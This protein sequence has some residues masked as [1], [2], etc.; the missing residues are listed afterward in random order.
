MELTSKVSIYAR[1]VELSQSYRRTQYCSSVA[2]DADIFGVLQDVHLKETI[3]HLDG[4][5]DYQLVEGGSNFSVGERQLIC[6]ARALLQGNKI[7]VMDEA[8]AN[9]DYRTD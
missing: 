9:V 6:L 8:T 4:R 1:L 2:S 5:P 3:K 7:I